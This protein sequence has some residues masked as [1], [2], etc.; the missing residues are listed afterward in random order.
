MAL[1]T[2]GI[3][4]PS[5]EEVGRDYILHYFKD[6]EIVGMDTETFGMCPHQ[7]PIMC[8]QIGDYYN[9]FVIHGERVGDF[10]K[11]L[12]EKTLLGHHLK[13]DLK[14]LYKQNIWPT[15][16][17]DTMLAEQVLHCG[18]NTVRHNLAAVALRRLG[19]ELDKSVRDG[20]WNEGL[21]ERVIQYAADDVK[22]LHDIRIKQL[23]DL[24]ELELE[25][26]LD[27]ENEFTLA[28][29]YI[30]FCGFKLDKE[31]WLAKMKKDLQRMEEAE[32]RLNQWILDNDIDGYVLPQ[33]D[34]FKE[35]RKVDIL[36][37][38]PKQVVKLF[39][40]L[41]IPCQINDRGTIKDSVEAS[42]IKKHA[43][44]F[45]II[46]I[47]LEYKAAEKVVGTYGQSFLD[48]INP[49]TGR[50]H[51]SF[52]QI[53]D[54]GRL[55]SGGKD[56]VTKTEYINMQNIP[57]DKETRA[58]FV[59]EDGNS[60]IICD[61]SGQEQIVLANYSLDSNLLEFYDQGLADMHSFVASKMHPELEGLTLDEIK[62]LHKDKRQKAKSAGFAINYGGNGITIA[63]NLG[64]SIEE[65][66][67]VYDGYF[68]AFPDLKRY[69][70]KVKKQGLEK[71]YILIDKVVGRKSFVYGYDEYKRLKRELDSN[72]W[73]TWKVLKRK[74]KEA[75]EQGAMLD[76]AT[77]NMYNEYKDKMSK[78]FKI[79]GEIE[80]KSLNY[81]IQGSSA[82]ITKQS[83]IYFFNWIKKYSLQN[84]VLICNT[85]HDE[86]VAEC[87]DYMKEYVAEAL[88]D[89]MVRAGEL[90]CK[91]VPLKADPCITPFWK[92]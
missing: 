41:G 72:F 29:A 54:T 82:N 3:N 87:P 74:K 1:Y 79:K 20:I 55:S 80:R 19:I 12:E 11:L 23:Q 17:Y 92:K 34:M 64:V 84:I 83:C 60:L 37:S 15:K 75:E 49:V 8:M 33:M 18:N 59:A 28:L 9:Q 21:T 38:S 2:Y 89:A 77:H 30:E 16:V 57:G 6:K 58:C 86:N 53:R 24:A 56:K 76:A 4:H 52:F 10:K 14:F 22:Y 35:E 66:N 68:E 78:F 44:K 27:L 31:K 73:D 39:K 90:Y 43:K 32:A 88:E 25:K 48:Q 63:E 71:G 65:G 26:T 13:F 50:I 67:A 47:Y 40:Q 46:D 70:E 85:I 62:E 45:P 69:F 61:Y 7:N 5:F 36:W 51:S 81:P 91:R 42:V